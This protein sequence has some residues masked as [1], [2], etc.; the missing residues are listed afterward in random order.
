MMNV[1]LAVFSLLIVVATGMII[2]VEIKE[3][4]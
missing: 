1:F 4:V 3:E 2:S